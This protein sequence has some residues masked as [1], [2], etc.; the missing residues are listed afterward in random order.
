LYY[1]VFR[2]YIKLA[3]AKTPGREIETASAHAV[4][5]ADGDKF[6][7]SRSLVHALGGRS[8]IAN[9]DNCITRLRVTVVD[10]SLVDASTLKSLGAAGVVEAGKAVQAIFGTRAGNIK[11]DI[12]VYLK[13]AGDDAELPKDARGK[14]AESAPT[15]DEALVQP[16]PEATADELASMR[17]AL[18]GADNIVRVE[19]LAATRLIV[20]LKDESRIDH[21]AVPYPIFRPERGDAVHVLVGL[22]PERFAKLKG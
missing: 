9:L 1:A 6:A 12:D 13:Q 15:G 16:V 21:S 4:A 3:D 5:S 10:P 14:R 18:G 22:Y 17:R 19:P 2:A 8:N 11:S 20:Q 7:F